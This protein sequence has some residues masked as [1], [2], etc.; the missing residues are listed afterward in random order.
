VSEHDSDSVARGSA[1]LFWAQ[2]AGNAGLF[3]GIVAITRALGPAGR[4]TIAFLTVTSMVM[5]QLARFGITEATTVFAAQRPDRRA[6][7]LTNSIVSVV[8][9]SSIAAVVVCGL[10]LLEPSWRPGGVTEEELALLGAGMIASALADAGYMFAVGTGRF[11]FHARVTVTTSWLY[12]AALVA[13][14][15]SVGLSVII[16]A[17]V[18]VAVQVIK[19][20]ILLVSSAKLTGLG[21]LDGRLLGES[22]G[23]GVRAWLGSL[24]SAFNDRVDQVLMAFIASHV[25][26][27]IYAAAV[28]ASEIL[29]YLP[30][31]A[32]TVALSVVARTRAGDR[33]DRTLRA[34]R[35]VAMVTAVAAAVAAL[36]GPFLLPLVFG[37]SFDGAVGPFLWLLPGA[38]GYVA[39]GIFSSALVASARPG[40]SSAGPFTSVVLGVTLDVLL[41]PG[42][43][44]TGAAIASTSAFLSGGLVAFLLFRRH[45][46]FPL[47]AL[48]VPR[49]GDLELLHAL[50]EPWRRRRA[51]RAAR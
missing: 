46:R 51:P 6:A 41:I 13:L 20:A 11:R 12:A 3:T 10:L 36:V 8:V 32:A 44:A 24:A 43:G 47:A 27:G 31:S 14:D 21:R 17:S 50:A 40:W 26:L 22:F 15:L 1:P 38:L 25:T 42:L 5:A 19:A 48:F 28:N 33:A 18:W 37:S 7:L 30:G 29:L 34:F 2:V 39:L 45:H 9:T 4:G 49:R 16:A 23:F 35:S